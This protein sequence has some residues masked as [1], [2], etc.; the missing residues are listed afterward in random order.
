MLRYVAMTTMLV[1]LVGMPARAE[2]QGGGG[3]RPFH[4]G[5]LAQRCIFHIR[6]VTERTSREMH[7]RTNHAVRAIH[8]LLEAGNT[9]EAEAAATRGREA[10]NRIANRGTTVIGHSSEHCIM[11]LT[12]REAPQEIIDGVNMAADHSTGLIAE[13]LAAGLARI[14]EALG[15]GE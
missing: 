2:F 15:G 3:D 12:E 13:R 10:L 6:Q 1:G 14:D 5:M 9:E 8:M 7:M 4:P 11:V